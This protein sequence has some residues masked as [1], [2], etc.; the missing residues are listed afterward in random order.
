MPELCNGPNVFMSS[1]ED[2]E[3]YDF[4]FDLALNA[5]LSSPKYER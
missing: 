5:I 2:R 4:Q 1:L 3:D